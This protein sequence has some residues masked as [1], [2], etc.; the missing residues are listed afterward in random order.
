MAETKQPPRIEWATLVKTEQGWHL[1]T[2]ATVGNKVIEQKLADP[3][4]RS[5]AESQFRIHA[6]EHVLDKGDE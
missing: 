3:V 4:D 1:A 5:E 6:I 2:I